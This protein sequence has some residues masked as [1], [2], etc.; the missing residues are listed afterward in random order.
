MINMF[1]LLSSVPSFGGLLRRSIEREY[2][3]SLYKP[4]K[5][6]NKFSMAKLTGTRTKH[7]NLIVVQIRKKRNFKIW[8]GQTHPQSYRYN[9]ESPS[10]L[11]ETLQFSSVS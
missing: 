1:D 9:M 3:L 4:N 8:N 6:C 5:S 2:I 11:C 7:S 10:I